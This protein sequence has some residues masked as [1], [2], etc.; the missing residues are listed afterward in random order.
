MSAVTDERTGEDPRFTAGLLHDVLSVLDRHGY[1]PPTEDQAEK[2]A[3]AD[4]MVALMRLVRAYE[5][6]DQ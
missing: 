5:G 3:Y 6:R 4:S 2:F 1:R